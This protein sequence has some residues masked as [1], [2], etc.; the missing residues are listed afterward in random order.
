MIYPYLADSTLQKINLKTKSQL[1]AIHNDLYVIHT[2]NICFTEEQS[3]VC[4]L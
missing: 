2:F 4:V 1:K 3:V